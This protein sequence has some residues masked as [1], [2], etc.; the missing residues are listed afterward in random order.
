MTVIKTS[1]GDKLFT[2]KIPALIFRRR[3]PWTPTYRYWAERNGVYVI[4]Y[5]DTIDYVGKSTKDKDGIASRVY[6]HFAD[7]L[8]S[9]SILHYT[10][11]LMETDDAT[12]LEKL[13]IK[14][15]NPACDVNHKNY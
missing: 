9:K 3:Q 7:A 14:E 1:E 10:V 2:D 4:Y 11:A 8:M 15:L 12:R 13:L 6:D 5:L